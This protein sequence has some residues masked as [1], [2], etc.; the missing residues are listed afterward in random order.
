MLENCVWFENIYVSVMYSHI[1]RVESG[2]SFT[3]ES[4]I[5]SFLQEKNNI[6]SQNHTIVEKPH[7]SNPWNNKQDYSFCFSKYF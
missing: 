6:K 4:Y 2:K 7:L 1:C 5:Y 3:L